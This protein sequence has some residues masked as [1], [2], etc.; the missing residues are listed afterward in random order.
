MTLRKTSIGLIL[1]LLIGASFVEAQPQPQPEG[2]PISVAKDAA[3]ASP[4][5]SARSQKNLHHINIAAQMHND[6]EGFYVMD[7]HDGKDKPLLSWRVALLR[8]LGQEELLKQFNL[9][10]PWD[11]PTNKP[12]LAKMPEVYKVGIEPE[13]N[14]KTYYQFFK[15]KGCFMDPTAKKGSR[16]IT[17]QGIPDGAS[18]TVGVIECGPPV[19]WTKPDDLATDLKNLD[20]SRLEQPFAEFIHCTHVSGEPF[21]YRA[22]ISP[23]TLRILICH[24]EGE[25]HPADDLIPWP[26]PRRNLPMKP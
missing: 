16:R 18:N 10:E 19:E 21:K 14:T 22:G 13:G 23:R 3:K 1:L 4:E 11:G 5:Q 9:E 25:V 8:D 24:Y 6:R 26:V 12:L 20:F 7:L 2:K 17:I 15:G